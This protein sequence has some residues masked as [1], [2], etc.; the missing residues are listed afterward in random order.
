M[1]VDSTESSL[2]GF[3]GCCCVSANTDNKCLGIICNLCI[4]IF[5]RIGSRSVTNWR[6]GGNISYMIE[7][8]GSHSSVYRKACGSSLQVET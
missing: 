6:K 7:Q 1:G 2:L 4:Y 8:P 3:S 5:S